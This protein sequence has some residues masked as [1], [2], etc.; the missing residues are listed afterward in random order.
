MHWM[1][2]RDWQ[3][4]RLGRDALLL[5]GRE[6][7]QAA[8]R[9]TTEIDGSRKLTIDLRRADT[10]FL[11]EIVAASDSYVPK[12]Q[13]ITAY[14]PAAT[15]TLVLRTESV[16]PVDPQQISAA[17]FSPD[18]SFLRPLRPVVGSPKKPG[19]RMQPAASAN[20][21]AEQEEVEL[22]ILFTLHG[23]GIC[24]LEPIEL[25][26]ESSG[27]GLTLSGR[28]ATA[29]RRDQVLAGNHAAASAMDSCRAFYQ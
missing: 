8:L 6:D 22:K 9:Q 4:Q 13:Q 23:L 28:F 2:A 11:I 21:H 5:S 3:P 18:A 12:I 1:E 27:N 29:A 14:S 7:Y 15:Y 17:V 19:F 10:R 16:K 25:R 24:T 20:S 26:R